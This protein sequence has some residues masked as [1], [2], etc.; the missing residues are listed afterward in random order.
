MNIHGKEGRKEGGKVEEG[1]HW[2]SFFLD[3]GF[4]YVYVYKTSVES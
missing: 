3:L 2:A 4:L 1:K